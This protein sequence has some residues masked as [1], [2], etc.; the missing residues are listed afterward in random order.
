MDL[1]LIGKYHLL[2]IYLLHT[3]KSTQEIRV[4]S[5]VQKHN[6]LNLTKMK[7]SFTPPPVALCHNFF[8][9]YFVGIVLQ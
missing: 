5:F 1:A 2:M 6:S 8:I 7:K 3:R 9:V 4:S